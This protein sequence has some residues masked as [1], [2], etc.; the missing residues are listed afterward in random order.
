LNNQFDSSF[1][2]VNQMKLR[3]AWDWCR[4]PGN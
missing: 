4:V 1:Q 3:T 2:L